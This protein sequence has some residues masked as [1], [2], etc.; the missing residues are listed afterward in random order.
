MG[1]IGNHRVEVQESAAY[2]WGWD[3]AEAGM[4]IHYWMLERLPQCE[5]HPMTKEPPMTTDLIE[6]LLEQVPQGTPIEV[7]HKLDAAAIALAEANAKLA[8]QAIEVEVL[9]D[10]R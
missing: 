9:N 6:R 5:I 7:C 1:K 8:A 4:S 10:M 3:W 2:K